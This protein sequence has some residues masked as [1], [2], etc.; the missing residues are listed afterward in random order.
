MK[1]HVV[2]SITR[3]KT[4]LEARSVVRAL[5]RGKMSQAQGRDCY[6]RRP[7]MPVSLATSSP[8]RQ[9]TSRVERVAEVPLGKARDLVELLRSYSH[10]LALFRPPFSW[11]PAAWVGKEPRS[12][13]WLKAGG[14]VLRVLGMM[15]G[16]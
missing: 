10:K 4:D 7:T 13:D 8:L 3:S 5:D 9:R 11:A 1:Q 6:Q 16:R 15:V 2:S 12:R 14:L